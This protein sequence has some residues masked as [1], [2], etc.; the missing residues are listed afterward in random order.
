MSKDVTSDLLPLDK[1]AKY[2]DTIVSELKPFCDR[3]EVVGSIRRRRPFVHDIDIVVISR[4]VAG[5]KERCQRN[6][7]VVADGEQNY[8]IRLVN[9][10]DVDI[11]IAR[12]PE[13]G[14]FGEEP[15]NLG[16]L[17]ITRTGSK[18]HNIWLV[19]LAEKK[20]LRWNP[21]RGL[22]RGNQRI[23]CESEEDVYAALD[24]NWIPPEKRE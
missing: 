12:P 22:I 13:R 3:I 4:D 14:L 21:Y 9:G 10:V 24:L 11:W 16:A 18:E 15:S 19:Q 7:V 2:A 20:G 1:A 5:M 23:A 6:A 8:Q 17:L